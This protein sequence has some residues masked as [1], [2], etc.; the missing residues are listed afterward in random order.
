MKTMFVSPTTRIAAGRAARQHGLSLIETMIGLVMGLIVTLVI[1]QV[2]GNFESQ[3]QRSVSGSTAQQSGLLAFTELEQDIRSAGAGLTA[4][5]AF[6]CTNVFSY[7][8]NG[9]PVISPLPAYSGSMPMVPVQITD[10]GAGSDTVTVKRGSDMLGAISATIASDMPTSSAVLD[11]NTV[12]GFCAG[13]PDCAVPDK[14]MAID[15][16]TGGCTL[17][18]ITSVLTGSVKLQHNPGG[19]GP[20]YNP[21]N[22]FQTANGWPGYLTGA[23]VVKVGDLISHAYTVNASNQLALT[24]VTV[25]GTTTTSILATDIVKI[26]AQYGIADPGAEDVN[27]W[28]NAT[29]LTGWNVLDKPKVKRIKA[30]RLVVVARSAKME[31]ADVTDPCTNVSGGVNNG[32]CAW[33]DSVADPAPL[34]D[35]SADA[36]WRKYRYRAYQTV[37]P[38]RNVI[39]AG[40]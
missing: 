37:I 26:K 8:E 11:M 22:G 35:L 31:G 7:Y 15:P 1:T 30:I 4:S 20:R 12:A 5:A 16:A 21:P 40:V 10:G 28:V 13:L 24:D 25:P 3:K 2:W 19:A 9:G 36:N 6:D 39:W 29:A 34:I 23:K 33:V 18:E 27:A 14:I 32:P 38:I 17:M